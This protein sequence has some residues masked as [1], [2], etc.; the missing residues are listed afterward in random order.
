MSLENKKPT[1]AGLIQL[2][3]L[4]E[5]QLAFFFI[6]ALALEARVSPHMISKHAIPQPH[7]RASVLLHWNTHN[8]LSSKVLEAPPEPAAPQVV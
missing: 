6:V 2:I 8:S 5:A 4:N 3:S 7:P 1:S